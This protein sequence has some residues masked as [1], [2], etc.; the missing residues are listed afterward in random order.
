MKSLI[1][2]LDDTLVQEKATVNAAFLESCRLATSRY[3][4]PVEELHQTIRKT[5]RS[6][7]QNS[8]AREYCV[9]IGISS[10]EGL[11]GSFNGNDENLKILREWAPTYRKES[12]CESLLQ[13]KIDDENL[14]D[15]MADTFISTRRKYHNVFDDS[16][17]ALNTFR[18][19]YKLGLL[20]NGAPDIQWDKILGAGIEKY[21]D[22]IIVSGDIG[23]GKPDPRI[24]EAMLSRLESTRNDTVMIGD[25]LRSDI[26]GAR[27]AGIKA[28]WINR[29]NLLNDGPVVPDM[30]I[31]NLSQL[32]PILDL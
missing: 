12:W 27:A 9:R 8:P 1:F 22:S 25:S 26:G 15:E 21:F 2:D 5:C 30:E 14:A 10:W 17:A 7:W 4:I 11:W 6:H 18:S 19:N 16:I 3:G 20:T 13:H 24:F 31:K 32:R 28:V 23:I 29:Y